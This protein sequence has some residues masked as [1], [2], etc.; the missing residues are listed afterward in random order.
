MIAVGYDCTIPAIGRILCPARLWNT[1]KVAGN[2]NCN[3]AS[4]RWMSSS[5]TDVTIVSAIVFGLSRPMSIAIAMAIAIDLEG[6]RSGN[7]GS[8][9]KNNNNN[10]GVDKG[11]LVEQY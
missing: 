9:N 4:T 11:R 5:Q 1:R 10:Y 7:D 3:K 6:H 2:K 8:K